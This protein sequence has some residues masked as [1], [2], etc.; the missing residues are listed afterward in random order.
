MISV[1]YIVLD[2]ANVGIAIYND[3]GI[4]TEDNERGIEYPAYTVMRHKSIDKALYEELSEKTMAIGA[5][6]VI[7][8]IF[9][10]GK[11][12][13]DIATQLKT[14]LES[15]KIRFLLPMSEAE[16]FLVKT[17][18][19]Y[20][21]ADPASNERVFFLH[22]YAQTQELIKEAVSLEFSMLSGNIKL[23]EPRMGRKDRFTSVS[24]GNYFAGLLDE[25]IMR[26]M[27]I[28]DDFET[29]KKLIWF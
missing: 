26:E 20:L 18:K 9:A 1:D 22:P 5:T 29:L 7:Y 3:L 16:E 21:N 15:K 2:I 19:K 13:S 24:Y 23:T 17:Q 4:V 8:P 14:K 10:S 12:N 11:L 27:N 28:E 6:P 25:N